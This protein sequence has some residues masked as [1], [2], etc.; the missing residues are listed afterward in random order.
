MTGEEA[1]RLKDTYTDRSVAFHS[2]LRDRLFIYAQVRSSNLDKMW[3]RATM[4]F[5]RSRDEQKL[6]DAVEEINA[7]IVN[8]ALKER[9]D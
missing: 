3:A 5:E 8:I 9:V 2:A 1:K 6:A 7:T 4:E